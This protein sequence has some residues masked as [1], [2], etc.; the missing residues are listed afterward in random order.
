MWAV[1]LAELRGW[2]PFVALQVPYSLIARSVEREL[3]PMAR[4]LDLAVT[5]WS[6]LGDGLLSGRY[7]SDRP[8]PD[9]TRVAGVARQRVN[10][11]NLAVADAVNTVALERG[12]TSPQVAIAWLQAQQRRA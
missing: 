11:R 10:E 7:G 2:S 5:T 1:T 9:D 12:A 4:A 3:L 8:Q 6:P